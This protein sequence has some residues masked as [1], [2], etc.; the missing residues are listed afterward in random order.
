MIASAETFLNALPQI[1]V[2]TDCPVLIESEGQLVEISGYD[3]QNGILAGG[4]PTI[5][6]TLPEA[7]EILPVLKEA[8]SK[9]EEE[10]AILEKK[11]VNKKTRDPINTMRARVKALRE[12]V[13]NVEK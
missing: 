6:A 8:L 11:G 2:I 3:R 10:L 1:K 12:A 9:T 5:H 13:A 7:K 4:Q